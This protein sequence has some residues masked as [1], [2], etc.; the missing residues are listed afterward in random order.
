[1]GYA[2]FAIV[3]LAALA[4]GAYYYRN[5]QR[6][7]VQQPEVTGI[8]TA[9]VQR[10]DLIITASGSGT[11]VPG[12]ETDLAFHT[13]GVLTEVLVEVGDDVHTGD[14]VARVDDADARKAVVVA[15]LQL[16]KARQA[17]TNAETQVQEVKEGASSAELLAVEAALAVA[18]ES[19]VRLISGADAR[20]VEKA[21]LSLDQA[22]NSLWSAQLKRDAEGGRLNNEIAYQSAQASVA[23]AE[24]SV[25]KAEL[26]LQAL[27][28]TATPAELA[29]ATAKV[30]QMEENLEDLLAAPTEDEIAA[31]EAQ[32]EQAQ[33]DVKQAEL[34]LEAAQEELEQVELLAPING[35]VMAV[36]ARVGE[37]ASSNPIV[38]LA[39]LQA[40]RVLFWVEESDLQSVAPGNAL[41]IVFEALPDFTFEGEI[42]SIDP[43]LVTVGNTPA[44][45]V[46]ATMDLNVNPVTLLSGM[47][48]EVE[49]T[50]RE[51]RNALLVPVQALRELDP[52]QYAVFVVQ[53]D[54]EMEL[55]PVQ[56]GL[57]DF[58][59]AQVLSGL[60]EGEVVRTGTATSSQSAS[61]PS[62]QT[63]PPG[64]GGFF[65]IFGGG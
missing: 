15:M 21:K 10:G 25:R 39:D 2:I 6:A 64:P 55:R 34:S 3:V 1:M 14:L 30:A 63:Q 28:E 47:N 26:D 4:G 5:R 29:D 13:G 44:V 7:Q 32:L 11:L 33:L 37:K 12:D 31:A 52:G 51:A 22:K 65:R 36:H 42:H 41:S 61:S 57:K 18:K 27:L 23:N 62:N 35:T 19:Y 8:S 50:A 16:A 53:P 60:Q 45:Q 20:E 46:W 9:Q 58:V 56:I 48:V 54:G 24:I 40:P 38:T 59:Y 49:V 17:L 43:A